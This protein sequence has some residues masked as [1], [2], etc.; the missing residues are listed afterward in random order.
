LHLKIEKQIAGLVAIHLFK[1]IGYNYPKITKLHHQHE[2]QKLLAI[3]LET[4]S[5]K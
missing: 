3:R 5:L 2:F 4:G 1:F